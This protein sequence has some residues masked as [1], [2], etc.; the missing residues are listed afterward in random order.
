MATLRLRD[1]D[2]I[3]T[4][5]DLIFRVLGYSHPSN[6]Y[7]CDVEYAPA[8]I[9]SSSNPKALRVRKQEAFYKFYED[10]GWRFVHTNFPQHTILHGMIG[11]KVVGIHHGNIMRIL[12]PEEELERLIRMDHKDDLLAA[13]QNVLGL[14]TQI[15]A[16]SETEFGV[17]G[18]M[19]HGFHHPQYSD[20]DLTIYGGK[21]LAKLYEVLMELYRHGASTMRNEFETEES[22]RGKRWRF[23]NYGPKDYVWHQKRKGIY[24]LFN[25]ERS[26]RV[27]KTEFEPVKDWYE[28]NNDYDGGTKI[29]QKGWT[30]MLARVLEDRDAPFVPSVYSIEALKV[31]S[32]TRDALSASRIVSYVE[33]FRMQAF[34]DEIVHVEGNL[35]TVTSP[36]REFCQVALTYCPRYYEQ[37]LK[38]SSRDHANLI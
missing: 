33:E 3:I 29:V 31:L 8:E 32:G 11:R 20:I 23:Q 17:F 9:F 2:A 36:K 13:M 35:E 18:S 7:I 6:A 37:V 12:R 15:S 5:E 38:V 1:R 14:I 28:I 22:V 25:D 24:A 26:R 21:N 19:L 16:L 10:E 34:K 27:I 4:K 30:R